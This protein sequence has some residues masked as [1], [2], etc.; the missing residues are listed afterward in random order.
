MKQEIEPEPLT[1]K[2]Q[3]GQIYKRRVEVEAQIKDILT[4]TPDDLFG[5][6]EVRDFDDASYIKNE[7]LAFLVRYHR[8][9]G[10]DDMVDRLV[11]VLIKRLK[12]QINK[13]IQVLPANLRLECFDEIVS[14]V[15]T[16]IADLRD[17]RAEYAQVSFGPWFNGRAIAGIRKYFRTGRVGQK[18]DGRKPE[19][20]FEA[21]LPSEVKKFRVGEIL[22]EEQTVLQREALSQLSDNERTAFLLKHL[23]QWEVENKDDSVLTISKYLGV[24]SRTVRYWLESAEKKLAEWGSERR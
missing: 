16:P 20:G 3:S 21:E 4:V 1:R 19:D 8:K 23:A 17:D 7:S 2:A 11:K 14:D 6:L 13:W 5:R 24:T 18:A 22:P 10:D 9:L 12:G 15:I